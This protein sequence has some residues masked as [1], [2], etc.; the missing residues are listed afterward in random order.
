MYERWLE[1]EKKWIGEYCSKMKK[2]QILKVVPATMG[3]LTLLFGFISA[4]SGYFVFGALG[5]FGMGALVCGFFLLILL[6]GLSPNRYKK[7]LEKAVKKIKLSETEKEQLAKEFLEA[8][9]D[10]NRFMTFTMSGPNV[11]DTPA[12]FVKS[13]HYVMLEGGSPYAII[14]R[15]SDVQEFRAAE[16]SKSA[17]NTRGNVSTTYFYTLYTIQFFY[18]GRELM[19]GEEP[20]EGMGFFEENLRDRAMEILQ[21]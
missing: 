4:P 5:G 1:S 11:K 20:D 15:L 6:P 19:G 2:Q 10:P 9:A 18:K 3:I 17:Y 14:V 12:R 16:E 8:E 13:E 7:K 21:N